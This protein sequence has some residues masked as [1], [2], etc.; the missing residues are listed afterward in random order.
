MAKYR[1]DRFANEVQREIAEII[2]KDVKDPRLELV[3]IVQVEAASDLSSARVYFS[4]IGGN[5]NESVISALNSAKGFIRM[6]LGKR[7]KA[8][9]VP[10]LSFVLDDSIAYGVMMNSKIQ[11]QLSEDRARMKNIEEDELTEDDDI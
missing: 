10:E 1:S 11:Q 9:I 2:R 3:S 7:L 8:R 4:N 5:S 6:Q